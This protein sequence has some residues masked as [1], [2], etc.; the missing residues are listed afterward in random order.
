[1]ILFRFDNYESHTDALAQIRQ[2]VPDQE[3]KVIGME[4]PLDPYLERLE[5]LFNWNPNTVHEPGANTPLEYCPKLRW[6]Q[7]GGA[8]SDWIHDLGPRAADKIRVASAS[9]I[10][11]IQMAEHI[12]GLLLMWSRRL[13]DAHEAKLQKTY[14]KV[15][16]RQLLEL[17][18][19][20]LLIVGMGRVGERT[21][22]LARAFGMRVSAVRSRPHRISS[23]VD[24]TAT[25][26][27]LPAFLSEADFL[28]NILPGNDTTR[29]F[30]D[31]P[32]FDKMKTGAFFINVG[33][34]STVN[35]EAL[36][37]AIDSGPLAGAALDVTETEPIPQASPLWTHPKVLLTGHY[38]GASPRYESRL[39]DL[40]IENLICDLSAHPLKTQIFPFSS[41]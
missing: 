23:N 31:A 27:E 39:L 29:H 38:A 37:K 25:P 14:L 21:A 24:S 17:Y 2:L 13:H 33:R 11:P 12:F 34:G 32:Q 4:E 3:L 40:F 10:H 16:R 5:I 6:I 8:G 19:Q 15:P 9:G 36:L 18:G 30:F 7:S 1:M 35:E 26:E 41:A 20:H 22:E 28:V